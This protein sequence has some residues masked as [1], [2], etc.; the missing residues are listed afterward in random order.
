MVTA[1]CD[2]E[3]TDDEANS[4]TDVDSDSDADT[5][6]S[7][8]TD[9]QCT[10]GEQWCVQGQCVPCD[11]SGT[12]C[13]LACEKDWEFYRRNECL[14]CACAPLNDCVSD[15]DCQAD[16]TCYAG[17][18]CWDWCPEGDPSCCYGNICRAS[19]CSWQPPM[20]CWRLGCP[21]GQQCTDEECVASDCTCW[22]SDW[23]CTDDCGGGSCV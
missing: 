6:L 11:N 16:E 2:N 13:D 10:P 15:E 17:R 4:D 19:G 12:V 3:D 22:E 1:Q 21:Q 18:F 14:A 23:L 7:C 8:Q 9:A 20:G 5:D